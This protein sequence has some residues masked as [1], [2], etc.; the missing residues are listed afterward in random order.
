M[1][2]VTEPDPNSNNL[3]P[4]P[5]PPIS[6]S[7]ISGL[8]SECDRDKELTSRCLKLLMQGR[9]TVH[10]ALPKVGLLYTTITPMKTKI[11]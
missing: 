3:P 7:L 11:S 8:E 10:S 9:L 1:G 4:T 5:N 6:Q 2:E